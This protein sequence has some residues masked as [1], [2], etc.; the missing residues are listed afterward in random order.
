MTLTAPDPTQAGARASFTPLQQ[1]TL[2]LL[3]RTGDPIEFEREFVDELID[4]VSAA[5]DDLGSGLDDYVAANGSLR[6]NKH[7]LSSVLACE[8]QAMIDERFSWTTANA[9][10]QVA[11]RAIH[12]LVHWRGEPIPMDLVDDALARLADEDTSLGDWVARLPSSDLAE[13]RAAA[14]ER[15]T[16]FDECFPPLDKRAQPMT[17]AAVR[18]PLDGP[19]VLTGKV[20]LVMGKPTGTESRK[21]IVD[22]KTGRVAQRHRDDLRFYA[23]VETLRTAVPPRKLASFYLDAGDAHVEDVS[24]AVLQ[25]AARRTV[26]GVRALVEL[27]TGAREPVKRVGPHCRWCP[28]AGTCAEGRKYLGSDPDDIEP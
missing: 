27:V 22:L 14:V 21:V 4:D 25:S 6:V 13:L 16:R 1:R 18:W 7:T 11:H 26:D 9:V 8:V 17:E 3:R 20:D 10:G 5:I 23:L 2:D 24:T 28:E 19:I 12:Q 15:V